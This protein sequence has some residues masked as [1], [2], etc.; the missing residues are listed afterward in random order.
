MQGS[1]GTVL[2]R[3]SVLG[4]SLQRTGAATRNDQVAQLAKLNKARVTARALAE[5]HIALRVVAHDLDRRELSEFLACD[6]DYSH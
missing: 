2:A 5:P 1:S 4:Y 3:M 6:V